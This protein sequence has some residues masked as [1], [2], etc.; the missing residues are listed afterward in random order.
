M[1]IIVFIL[2]SRFV[3]MLM[4]HENEINNNNMHYKFNISQSQ[5]ERKTAYFCY[6]NLNIPMPKL[7]N[8]IDQSNNATSAPSRQTNPLGGGAKKRYW[9]IKF[10][11]TVDD[12]ISKHY[13]IEFGETRANEDKPQRY[14]NLYI[15]TYS[16]QTTK[17]TIKMV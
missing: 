3:I 14:S 13:T 12:T 16:H 10:G 1:L 2:N 17:G 7:S 11:G 9:C 5:S 15:S 8:V 4:L 6:K